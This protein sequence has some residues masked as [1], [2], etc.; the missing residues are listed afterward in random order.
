MAA[1]STIGGSGGAA[2][3]AIYCSKTTMRLRENAFMFDYVLMTLLPYALYAHFRFA[4]YSPRS[5]QRRKRQRSEQI[6]EF[7][8]NEP[9]VYC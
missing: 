4:R 1:L 7:S 9:V 5:P 2:I 3:I 8:L 6:K